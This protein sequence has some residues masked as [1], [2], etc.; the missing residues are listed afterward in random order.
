MSVDHLQFLKNKFIQ[1]L[2]EAEEEHT[3]ENEIPLLSHFLGIKGVLE[4]KEITALTPICLKNCLYDAMSSLEECVVLSEKREPRKKK[5]GPMRGYTLTEHWFMH[6]TRRMLLRI[7]R[8]LAGI[9]EMGASTSSS[10]TSLVSVIQRP[11]TP[12]RA[13]VIAYYNFEEQKTK[14]LDGLHNRGKGFQEIVILGIGGSGKTTLARLV[15]FSYQSPEL[16]DIKI[17]VHLL[18]KLSSR[19]VVELKEIIKDMLKQCNDAATLVDDEDLSEDELLDDEDLS[20]DELLEILGNALKGKKYLIVFDGIWDINIDWYLKLKQKLKFVSGDGHGYGHVIITTRL[21]HKARMMV[22]SRNLYHIQP[23]PSSSLEETWKF[24]SDISYN[25][26]DTYRPKMTDEIV[27]RSDGFP[28]ALNI[29][30]K[31]IENRIWNQR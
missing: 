21:P 28:L 22:G 20:E 13:V 16:C 7:Q 1:D 10:F 9:V 15:S 12:H 2:E 31:V 19:D 25:I 24:L 30:A 14:I 5:D 3:G 23:L 26:M 27:E 4:A 11:F 6:K 18:E 29:L 8:K 17:W